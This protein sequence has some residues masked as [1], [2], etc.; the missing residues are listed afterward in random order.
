[1]WHGTDRAV[2]KRIFSTNEWICEGS[3]ADYLGEGIY[4]SENSKYWACNWAK[5]GKHH[6]NDSVAISC[7]LSVLKA[8][9]LDFSIDE[10]LYIFQMAIE[11]MTMIGS[12]NV[13]PSNKKHGVVID[14][15]CDVSKK[16]QFGFTHEIKV[17][18]AYNRKAMKAY[19]PSSDYTVIE[20]E[21]CVKDPKLIELINVEECS[22]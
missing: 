14:F 9:I 4:F 15:I 19:E 3:H 20:I 10:H 17:V 7:S 6:Y 5:K 1:L 8:N 13:Q 21:V 18:K 16:K 2:A 11:L 22:E 12:R